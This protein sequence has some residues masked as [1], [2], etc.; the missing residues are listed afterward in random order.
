MLTPEEIAALRRRAK[1]DAAWFR[2]EFA[3]LRRKAMPHPA[4]SFAGNWTD[5]TFHLVQ[6]NGDRPPGRLGRP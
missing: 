4:P 1:E 6:L 3:D 5:E 2:K